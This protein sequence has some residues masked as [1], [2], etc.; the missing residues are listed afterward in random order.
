MVKID[1]DS[2]DDCTDERVLEYLESSQ[3]PDASVTA[4]YVTAEVL[5]KVSFTMSE[6]NPALRVTK[7]VADYCSLHRNLRLDLIN[8]KPKKAVKH[9]ISV[10]GRP[11]SKF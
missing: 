6:K 9:L 5:A 1:A 7:A 11:P 8:G 2:V 3:E 4:E 10:S